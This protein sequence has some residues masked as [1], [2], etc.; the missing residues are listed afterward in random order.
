[1]SSAEAPV[2]ASNTEA[3]FVSKINMSNPNP[4]P[5][6]KVTK[7]IV[8]SPHIY[9]PVGPYS[10]AILAGNTLYVSGLLGMD[11]QARL[12]CGGAEAQTRQ[13]L[14]NLKQVLEAG[15][16]SLLAVVKTT[17]L[18]ANMDDFQVV[19]QVY[20]EYFTKDCPARASYQVARLPLGASVEIEVVALSGDLVIAEAGPCPCARI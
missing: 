11:S 3:K 15:G 10:Q 17:V 14:E 6:T 12:V 5:Q 2:P 18:L 4:L 19:N 16:S 13:A 1:M 7:T 9:K 20:A 8:T